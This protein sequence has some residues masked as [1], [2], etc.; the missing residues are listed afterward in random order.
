[1]KTTLAWCLVAGLCACGSSPASSGGD[2][3]NPPGDDDGGTSPGDGS[4]SG[5]GSD[6]TSLT[7][8]TSTINLTVAGMARTAVLYVPSSA[9]SSSQLAIAL[10][11]NGDS[12]TNFLATSGLEPLADA[13]GTVLVI[14][15]GIP[16]DIT[17]V[18]AGG[19][20]IPADWDAYNSEAQGNIDLPLLDAL[21]TQIVGTGQV[22][23]HHVFVFGYSQGGYL[24][25]EYGMVT[26]SSLACS[27]VLSASS[28]FGGGAGDPLISGAQRKLPV[29]QQIGT[30]DSAFAQAQQTDTTL[31]NDGFVHEFHAV[32]GAGHVPIPGDVSVP[33][34]FCRSQS[35]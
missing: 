18:P 32:Q 5:S 23:A 16:R 3:G 30:N 33:W 22:D 1:M 14:P 19:Q 25:F 24:S 27:A 34:T 9:T 12:D 2:G 13:D 17:V 8:G 15:Q 10:H 35:H 20:V 21:R 31:G 29:V 28:P 4:G 7:P 11:G 6:I 26:G